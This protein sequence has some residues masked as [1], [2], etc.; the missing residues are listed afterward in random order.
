MAAFA[1]SV[2]A[3]AGNLILQPAGFGEHSYASW[4]GNEG[5]ADSNGD[6]QA[7]YLQKDT[8]TGLFVAGAAVV[9]NIS[10]LPVN[11]LEGLEWWVR[12]DSH[13][14]AG[15][16]RWN[17][18]LENVPGTIFIGCNEMVPGAIAEA[19]NGELYQQR[20]FPAGAITGR[21]GATNVISSLVILFDE[22]NDQGTC[23]TPSGGSCVFLDNILVQTTS[24]NTPTKCWE[25]ARDNSNQSSG[26][27]PEQQEAS[28]TQIASSLTTVLP[29]GVAVDPTDLAVV[30]ALGAI[31]PGVPATSWRLYPDVLY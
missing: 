20:T 18:R 23:P 19:P 22:G 3:F 11:K 28:A 29:A 15:A 7:L 10:G 13:C 21:L 16:P 4:K 9:K 12:L 30:D 31:F 14:G 6:A 24:P 26:L 17:V 27:C 2:P 1:F 25:S 8:L 5:L